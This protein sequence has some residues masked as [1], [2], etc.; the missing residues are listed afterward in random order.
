[1]TKTD[2]QRL[3]QIR[4]E[5]AKWEALWPETTQTWEATFLLRIIDEL[6]AERNAENWK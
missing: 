6:L 4:A 5:N 2:Q 1:M 3:A